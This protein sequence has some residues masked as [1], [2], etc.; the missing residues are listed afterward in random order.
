MNLPR[1]LAK[2]LEDLGHA[3]RHTGDVGLGRA[4]DA[5]ILA[6]ALRQGEVVLTHDL[7]YGRLHSFLG[8]SG[9][10]VVILRTRNS[11]A[12]HLQ[13][14]LAAEWERIEAPLAAGAV[15]VIED[16]VTRIR[17]LPIV[18]GNDP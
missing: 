6:E 8:A 13:S 3:A 1:G 9:P 4:D 5:A 7:D 17:R 10:S 18:R 15:V 2:L 16:R 11:S 12:P 14:R